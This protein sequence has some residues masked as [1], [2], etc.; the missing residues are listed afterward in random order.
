MSS[1]CCRNC[2]GFIFDTVGFGCGLGSCKV[3]QHYVDKGYT[4]SQ[5]RPLL[6]EL[7]NKPYYPLFWGSTELRECKHFKGFE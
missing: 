6:V 7:G 2:R 1:V 3:Y 5:L 4:D